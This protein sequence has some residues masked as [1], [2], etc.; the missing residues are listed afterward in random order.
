MRSSLRMLALA[1]ILAAA[2]S[3]AAA[4]VTIGGSE[5][6][7]NFPFQNYLGSGEYQQVYS[8]AAF[9]N[10]MWISFIQFF[11]AP[12]WPNPTFS[13][14]SFVI[15]FSETSYTPATITSNYA[16]NITG[17]NSLFFSGVLS[18]DATVPIAGTPYLYDPGLGNLLMDVV[19]TGSG[20]GDPALA[21]GYDA[22]TTR[23][24]HNNVNAD[25][26]LE[27]EFNGSQQTVTPEPATMVL[28]GTGLLGIGGVV[29]RRRKSIES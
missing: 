16:T 22:N 1:L 12:G 21:F 29:R 26:G 19:M 14:N 18:G 10:P 24:Y 9:A 25:Y 8:S 27:T 7:N 13:G 3:P 2:S 17:A 5:S 6:N 20:V 4:Q 15:S 23:V 11:A 28:L